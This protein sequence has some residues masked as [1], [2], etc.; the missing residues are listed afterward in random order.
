M[1]EIV[2]S[3]SIDV[4]SSRVVKAVVPVP[5]QCMLSDAEAASLP[6]HRF[7]FSPAVAKKRGHVLENICSFRFCRQTSRRKREA[8]EIDASNI[9]VQ[10]QIPKYHGGITNPLLEH[11]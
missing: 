4:P 7:R 8:D 5:N 10:C 6:H 1:F 9:L 3:L 11:N 2:P